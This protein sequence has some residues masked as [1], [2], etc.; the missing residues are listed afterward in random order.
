MDAAVKKIPLSTG[1]HAYNIA[2]GSDILPTVDFPSGYKSA[3]KIGFIV[4]ER[5][6]GLHRAFIS[7]LFQ[8][9]EAYEYIMMNDGE[10][11]KNYR[12]AEQFFEW[13][14]GKGFTRKSVMIAIGG[15]VV[16]DFAGYC[17]ALFMRGIPVVH[18]PTTLL[19]MVDSSIGGKVAVNIS[20]GKNIVGVFYQ[21]AMVVSDIRFLDTLPDD[22]L[23]N[24]ITETVK[25][26]LIGE[27][28]LLTMM[29]KHDLSSIKDRDT[30][31]ELIYLSAGFKAGVVSED[32][33]ESGRRAI[34][35]F[36][37]TI[38]H[39]IESFMEYRGISHGEAVAIGLK[40]AMEISRELGY[41]SREDVSVFD[42]CA[43]RYELFD[44]AHRFDPDEVIRH[45]KYDKKNYGGRINFVLLRS[46]GV[47]QYDCEVP[48]DVLKHVLR[49]L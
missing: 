47:P 42:E 8:N 34:L 31:E 16:G 5:V 24:G 44:K 7:K 29:M 21:P 19:A 37:H 14:L 20:A 49:G 43:R 18:V 40:G 13:L 41:I 23:K 26:A 6:W 11:N 28:S 48:E 22:E 12:Y 25:H 4:S 33:K 45:M 27:S 46:M 32:E 1:G 30:L 39:A 3:D 9:A 36:G 2:I 15:G 38:G 35:N 17:A 10:E